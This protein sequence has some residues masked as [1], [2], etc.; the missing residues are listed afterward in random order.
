MEQET[1]VDYSTVFAAV[2]AQFPQ[3]P[4]NRRE[5]NAR[6]QAD[7]AA[8]WEAGGGNWLVRDIA[9]ELL[10]FAQGKSSAETAPLLRKYGLRAFR[11]TRSIRAMRAI[12]HLAA[13]YE[14]DER[15][16]TIRRDMLDKAWDGIGDENGT[17]MA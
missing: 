9:H 1:P 13:A 4:R 14:T 5:E 2:D 17:W 8:V 12:C 7:A 11:A 10:M 16:A 3:P 15:R 6:I